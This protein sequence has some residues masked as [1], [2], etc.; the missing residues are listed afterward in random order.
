MIA[1]LLI[2]FGKPDT[3]T[4]VATSKEAEVIALWDK[5]A[6][7]FGAC[8]LGAGTFLCL[9]EGPIGLLETG[10][11]LLEARDFGATC[12]LFE[13]FTVRL[14]GF[15]LPDF[16]MI[17]SNDCSKADIFGKSVLFSFV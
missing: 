14:D 6:D 16:E 4:F 8:C 3:T 12:G 10:A 2:S 15:L 5:A 17:A 9:D 13:P 7:N 1:S 11:R